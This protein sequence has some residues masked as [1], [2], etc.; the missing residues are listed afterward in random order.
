MRCGYTTGTC[1]AAAAYAAAQ[2][3]LLHKFQKTVSLTV[4]RGDVV[5]VPVALESASTDYV[6]C[7]AVKDSGDDPDITN[8][9]TVQVSVSLLSAKGD[10]SHSE[11]GVLIQGGKGIGIVTKPGLER[12]VGEAAINS[13]PKQM[14]T[15]AVQTVASAA[16]F[17][18]TLQ[19]LISVPE[20]ET[21]AKQT[22]NPRLGIEGGI[23]ILGT[24]GIVEPMSLNALLETIKTE[25]RVRAAEYDTKIL[26]T[27]CKLVAPKRLILTPGNY[28][29]TFCNKSFVKHVSTVI[30]SNYIGYSLDYAVSQGF[31][32]ILLV[33]HIGKFIK[34]A[35]GIMDTHSKTA[36]CRTELIAVHAAACGTPKIIIEKLLEAATTES[37]LDLLDAAVPQLTSQII[38]R[39]LLRIQ[40]YL[41]NRVSIGTDVKC[42]A[43]LF[44]QARG[45]IGQTEKA[46]QLITEWE[47]L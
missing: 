33:G 32:S 31:K 45:S 24:S 35:G 17:N 14:I 42:G 26:T 38:N 29:Q 36:D 23:S 10:P 2:L 39:I 41:D 20:G 9:I 11:C 28:G 46:K 7:S 30:C 27:G 12:K 5:T 1:A 37:C 6:C 13:V 4:P 21:I 25:I 15:H 19:V 18:G 43:W 47:Q 3:L 44:S 34:L 40:S 22:F 16:N 8:G